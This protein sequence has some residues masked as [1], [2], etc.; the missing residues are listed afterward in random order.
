MRLILLFATPLLATALAAGAADAQTLQSDAQLDD[1][2]FAQPA[3]AD[4]FHHS[5]SYFQ[6]RFMQAVSQSPERAA[7]PARHINSP[8][9]WAAGEGGGRVERLALH[10]DSGEL[11]LA[12]GKYTPSFG[13]SPE[14]APSAFSTE[15][16]HEYDQKGRVG[17]GGAWRIADGDA[18]AHALSLNSYFIESPLLNV[19]TW[20]NPDQTAPAEAREIHSLRHLSAALDGETAPPLPNFSYHLATRYQI[21]GE[22]SEMNEF[23]YVVALHSEIK[24][25]DGTSLDPLVEY[26]Y[27]DNDGAVSLQRQYLTFG[28]AGDRGP[29]NLTLTYSGRDSMPDDPA[30]ETDRQ[31]LRQLMLRYAFEDGS[32]LDFGHRRDTASKTLNV[33]FAIPL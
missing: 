13:V 12:A 19:S 29:W 27:F 22:E 18:G 4:V 8:E 11:S 9:D 28:V 6:R 10:Y 24:L 17:F 31:R 16:K 15:F 26:A 30:L 32:T 21:S 23:G 7:Q 3:L 2:N 20:Q 25:A 33:R 1:A 5:G 14:L